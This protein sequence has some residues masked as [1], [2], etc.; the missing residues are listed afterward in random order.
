MLSADEKLQSIRRVVIRDIRKIQ[1]VH[2]YVLDIYTHKD[3]ETDSQPLPSKPT[4]PRLSL[5]HESEEERPAY[6][7]I[8]RFRQFEALRKALQATVGAAKRHDCAYCQAFDTFLACSSMQPGRWVKWTKNT[9]K[10]AVVLEQCIY[11]LVRLCV[12]NQPEDASPHACS[13]QQL[14]PTIVE[15]FLCSRVEKKLRD[16]LVAR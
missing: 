16:S 7:V 11:Q 6:R 5:P 4:L 12:R 10:R 14:V 8:K 2:Y 15:E 13:A 3:E 1:R 9:Q